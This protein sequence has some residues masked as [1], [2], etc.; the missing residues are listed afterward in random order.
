MYGE[1]VKDRAEEARKKLNDPTTKTLDG[2]IIEFLASG[3]NKLKTV[4]ADCGASDNIDI[5]MPLG[6]KRY[7]MPMPTQQAPGAMAVMPGI[8]SNP[9]EDETI[10]PV[11]NVEGVL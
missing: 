9:F 4:I 2:Y 7:K 3:G 8:G 1:V 11:M 10:H 6:G 5:N